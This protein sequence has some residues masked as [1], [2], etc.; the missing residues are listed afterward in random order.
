MPA[1]KDLDPGSSPRQGQDDLYYY[2]RSNHHVKDFYYR[3]TTNNVNDCASCANWYA[4][5]DPILGAWVDFYEVSGDIPGEGDDGNNPGG[6][7]RNCYG[8]LLTDIVLGGG[9]K[10]HHVECQSET[11]AELYI[12]SDPSVR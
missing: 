11:D 2:F 6:A 8:I 10:G 12:R 1:H 5:S 9:W 3:L 7:V 4:N